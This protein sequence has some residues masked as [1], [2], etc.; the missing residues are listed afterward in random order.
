VDSRFRFLNCFIFGFSVLLEVVSFHIPGR[1]T[2][3]FYICSGK[4]PVLDQDIPVKGNT[5]LKV[6]LL[7]T[8]VVHAVL[9]LKIRHFKK[10][11]PVSQPT[12]SIR[13]DKKLELVNFTINACL[14]FLCVT[15]F[16]L[17]DKL[18]QLKVIEFNCYPNYLYEYTWRFV[19]PHVFGITMILLHFYKH[20]NLRQALISRMK[21]QD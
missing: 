11:A 13:L 12:N 18:N 21:C 4:N 15:A 5:H 9:I 19:C 1:N 7:F 2:L 8:V 20:P 10:R 14:I 16:L 3:Y 17:I 6:L